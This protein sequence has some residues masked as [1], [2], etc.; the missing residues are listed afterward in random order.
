MKGDRLGEFE[1][2]TLLAVAGAG[3]RRLTGSPCSSC[4]KRKCAA[5]C[6]WARSTPRSSG[7][8]RK[9]FL[10]SSLR[11]ATATRG[12]KRKRVFAVTTLG[13]AHAA[14]R[15]AHPRSTVDGGGRPPP[16]GGRGAR[17]AWPACCCAGSF[18]PTAGATRSN[19]ISA[20]L[21]RA[22]RL[23]ARPPARDASLLVR[24]PQFLSSACLRRTRRDGEG[25]GTFAAPP[26]ALW[27][28]IRQAVRSMRRMPAF[29]MLAAVT[30]AVGFT[31]HFAA[32]GIVDRLLLARVARRGRCRR[33]CAGCT[34]I[35]PTSAAAASSRIRVRT[36][37]TR[38]SA[39]RWVRRFA[40]GRTARRRPASAPARTPGR[41][42]VAFADRDYFSVLGAAAAQGRVLLP[43]DDPAPAGTLVVR[44]E[45]LR[46]GGAAFG[47][48]P[49]ALGREGSVS[50]PAPSPSSG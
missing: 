31:A 35:A 22:A 23:R 28:D 36:R 12:G 7:W 6:R 20:D 25:R 24:R 29:F 5:K 32:F 38:T 50:A 49:T 15:A 40:S 27:F 43:E 11:E 10:D 19:K 1:E 47:A 4:S 41:V 13:A 8:R 9:G 48:D 30:L 46:S 18:R 34:P 2:L 39:G 44:V 3:A 21:F 16:G 37:Y 26:P 33:R 17:R 45:R 14:R 42:T